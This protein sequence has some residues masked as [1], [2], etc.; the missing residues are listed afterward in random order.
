MMNTIVQDVIS[1]D[2]NDDVLVT[3]VFVNALGVKR[4]IGRMFCEFDE[5]TPFQACETFACD[6]EHTLFEADD[7]P[8][9]SDDDLCK[10]INEGLKAEG[11]PRTDEGVI[12]LIAIW[13][14]S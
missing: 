14:F 9:R 12:Q 8:I 5:P 7:N 11:L 4:I 2:I 10:R 13:I 6:W 3:E 1:E